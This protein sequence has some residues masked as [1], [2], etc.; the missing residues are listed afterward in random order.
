MLPTASYINSPLAFV[1]RQAIF[2]PTLTLHTR[3]ASFSLK[4]STRPDFAINRPRTRAFQ[5]FLR[6][7]TPSC[8]SSRKATPSSF[9]PR[10]ASDALVFLS[11]SR[12]LSVLHSAPAP[13]FPAL[14]RSALVSP[15]RPPLF[16]ALS[17]SVPYLIP[18]H[19]SGF[20][21]CDLGLIPS[22]LFIELTRG[23]FVLASVRHRSIP[24][25]R[26]LAVHYPQGTVL[27]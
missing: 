18:L 21:K 16:L 9:S 15:F 4:V 3:A 1:V 5:C 8:S 24:V 27:W 13:R 10:A 25:A 2:G 19:V 14:S 6:L 7:R 22:P 17:R 20:P 12:T 26:W 23:P 11:A